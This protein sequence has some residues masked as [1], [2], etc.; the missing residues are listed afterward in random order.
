[1]PAGFARQCVQPA[2][3]R[4]FTSLHRPC[5]RRTDAPSGGATAQAGVQILTIY[6]RPS[7]K[8]LGTHLYLVEV[9]GHPS[10]WTLKNQGV[11]R[12]HRQSTGRG[13]L[14]SRAH[15]EGHASTRSHAALRRNPWLAPLRFGA[16]P[17]AS[18]DSSVVL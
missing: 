2:V 7:R 13:D 17:F 9:A 5:W 15:S 12:G 6:E 18:S 10:G 4:L 11:P 3:R 16:K 14:R 1:M 8:T